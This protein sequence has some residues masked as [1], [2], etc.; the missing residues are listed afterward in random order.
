MEP[1][2]AIDLIKKGLPEVELNREP[3]GPPDLSFGKFWL[4]YPRKTG[5]KKAAQKKFDALSFSDRLDA[6]RGAI[7]HRENNPQWQDK[8]LVPHPHTFL[9]QR[10]WENEITARPA[11]EAIANGHKS[12]VEAVWS[13]MTQMFPG[14]FVEK[15]GK[16]PL[17]IW[18]SQVN[19]MTMKQ[20]TRG[21][22]KVRDEGL[23]HPP[24]LPYFVK[25]CRTSI[26]H[27][28]ESRLLPKAASD[29]E[30]A[31]AAFEEMKKIL[32]IS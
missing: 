5:D 24:G 31:A 2:K 25:L 18:R 23:E 11:D 26:D 8:G 32:N 6:I 15:Y 16:T 27:L 14:R 4:E 9:N 13:A 21:L 30:K 3:C 1:T 28:P 20:I 29:P 17:P 10:R 7:Y 22:A 19:A 12:P